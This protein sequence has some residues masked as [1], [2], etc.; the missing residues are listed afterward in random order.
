MTAAARSGPGRR[1]VLSGAAAALALSP[2]PALGQLAGL[3]VLAGGP[4]G[5][6]QD[7]LA[8]AIAEG[9]ALTKLTPRAMPIN[10]PR[11]QDALDSF[12][13]GKRPR[14]ALMVVGLSTIGGLQVANA[15][16]LL[17]RSHPLCR[18]LG[19]HLPLVVR[20][21]SK[22][23]SMQE[24][25]ESIRKDAGAISW[26][27]R[28]KG[29][30]DHQLALRVTEAAGGD[31][32]RLD[33][34]PFGTS[35]EASNAALQGKTTVATGALIEFVAQIKGGTLRALALASPERAEGL[36]IPTLKEAGLDVAHL[37][38]RGVVSR[39]AVGRT[40]IDRYGEAIAR[41]VRTP[42]WIE[43]MKQRYWV[44]LF[45][46]ADAFQT[47]LAA[48]RLRVGALLKKAGPL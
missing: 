9:L 30:A 46:P 39:D 33:Y 23:R 34:R 29:S 42:G 27:G 37:N 19:E 3:E 15:G 16:D 38:W 7:Q 1:E 6:G 17:D 41:V 24:L 44:D 47:F 4:P 40:L 45:Q 14:A 35:A 5:D 2:S 13:S 31:I 32:H 18:V 43:L 10:V 12:L 8:R 28:G 22:L 11:D 48:E 21:D 36:D 26:T 25:A 20:A